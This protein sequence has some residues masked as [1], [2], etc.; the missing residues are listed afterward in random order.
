MLTEGAVHAADLDLPPVANELELPKLAMAQP[1]ARGKSARGELG[2]GL[3][4]LLVGE[5]SRR[6]REAT[7]GR[8][9]GSRP[10]TKLR[11]LVAAGHQTL[12][13]AERESESE[14]EREREGERATE[15]EGDRIRAYDRTQSSRARPTQRQRGCHVGPNRRLTHGGTRFARY[16]KFEVRYI[17]YLSSGTK[18]NHRV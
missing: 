14:S 15:C 18:I 10:A 13:A 16:V 8:Y 5:D 1:P 9:L 11:T 4:R 12:A 2:R 7:G 17:R 6:E 3:C